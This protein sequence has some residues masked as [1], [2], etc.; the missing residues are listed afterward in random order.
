MKIAPFP[1]ITAQSFEA[2]CKEW[3]DVILSKES[4]TWIWTPLNAPYRRVLQFQQDTPLQRKLFGSS[5]E[6]H[7]LIYADLEQK[8]KAGKRDLHESIKNSLLVHINQKKIQELPLPELIDYATKVKNKTVNIFVTGVDQAI[9][10]D[11]WEALDELSFLAQWNR[12]TSILLF[13]E[14][15]ITH[16]NFFPKFNK[17]TTLSQNIYI[18][19]LY[20]RKDTDMFI[21]HMEHNWKIKLNIQQ[22]KWIDENCGGHFLLVK[23][24]IRNVKKNNSL[25]VKEI[26][27]LISMEMRGKAIIDNLLPDQKQVLF[28]VVNGLEI[29]SKLYHSK[30]VLWEQGFFKEENKKVTC[31][32]PFL[33]RFIQNK[34]QKNQQASNLLYSFT[35]IEMKIYECFKSMEGKIIP[36]EQLAEIIW[37][38]DWED[39]YSDWAIDQTIHRIRKKMKEAKLPYEIKT[40]KGVGFILL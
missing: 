26:S 14:T 12:E 36:R 21:R 16:P 1:P 27:T 28:Q 23:D 9:R 29:N 34:N 7:I 39:M 3:V 5:Y 10:N 2:M 33:N 31:N 32:V 20:S 30:R 17:R 13:V 38:D 6:S 24:V 18:R 25:P 40:K 35:P 11:N 19:P 37:E 8:E 4:G 15:D 22:E